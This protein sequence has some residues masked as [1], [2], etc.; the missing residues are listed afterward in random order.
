[1]YLKSYYFYSFI[2]S[3]A[4]DKKHEKIEPYNDICE[5]FKYSEKD[6]NYSCSCYNAITILSSIWKIIGTKDIDKK[7][8]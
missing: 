4:P 1:M 8:I 3:R 5:P 2:Q 7:I 6:A